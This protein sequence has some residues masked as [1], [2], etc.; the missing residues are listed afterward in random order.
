VQSKYTSRLMA[1][2]KT[3]PKTL[4]IP[5]FS[6]PLLRSAT[7]L[8]LYLAGA[9]SF[10]SPS[11]SFPPS[12]SFPP[13]FFFTSDVDPSASFLAFLLSNTLANSTFLRYSP[14][15]ARDWVISFRSRAWCAC[16]SY[17]IYQLLSPPLWKYVKGAGG[18]LKDRRT[19]LFTQ[20][21]PFEST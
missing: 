18:D 9:L 21:L 4:S 2:P 19:D 1:H 7:S 15:S 5:F 11:F 17:A 8:C 10:F 20:H 6:I 12:L 14:C 16:L 3:L 13:S